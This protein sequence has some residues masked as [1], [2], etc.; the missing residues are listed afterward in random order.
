MDR[1]TD[2]NKVVQIDEYMNEDFLEYMKLDRPIEE[3]T[4]TWSAEEEEEFYRQMAIETGDNPPSYDTLKEFEYEKSDGQQIYEQIADLLPFILPQFD[5]SL[6]KLTLVGQIRGRV[7]YAVDYFTSIRSRYRCEV[8]PLHG[9]HY[10]FQH[11]D[12]NIK[13]Q[14][15]HSTNKQKRMRIEFNPNRLTSDES[16]K[17]LTNLLGMLKEVHIT[18]KD[19]A[20]DIRDI[21]LLGTF[22]LLDGKARKQINYKNSSGRLETMYLGSARSEKKVRIYDK[23]VESGLNEAVWWRV[24]AQLRGRKVDEENPFSDFCFI[25]RDRWKDK[26]LKITERAMLWYILECEQGEP[27]ELFPKH[28]KNKLKTLMKQEKYR[29]SLETVYEQHG[30]ELQKQ[31]DEWTTFV[32]GN[33]TIM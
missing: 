30:A 29:F 17:E 26:T 12:T 15:D 23:A 7:A 3:Y 25:K 33:A 32:I 2:T 9:F 22:Y 1:Q 24:E 27:L 14:V 20:I 8:K 19:V 10:F 31:L 21:D 6:D 16:K 4:V 18:R 28:T 11:D 5:V 13:V